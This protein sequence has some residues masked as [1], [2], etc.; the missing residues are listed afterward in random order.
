MRMPLNLH[1]HPHFRHQ[2]NA[3]H[4]RKAP[5][6]AT[7]EPMQ[8][9]DHLPSFGQDELTKRSSVANRL[10]QQVAFRTLG[11]ALFAAALDAVPMTFLG[12]SMTRAACLRPQ[13]LAERSTVPPRRHRIRERRAV[14]RSVRTAS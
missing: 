13:R 1:R 8:I 12:S 6:A 5:P 9:L 7:T 10:V 2:T 14:G 4:I 11:Q 3:A